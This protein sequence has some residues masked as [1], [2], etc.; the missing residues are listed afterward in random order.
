VIAFLLGRGSPAGQGSQPGTAVVASSPSPGGAREASIPTNTT[1]TAPA[2]GPVAD[3]EPAAAVVRGKVNQRVES[4]GLA[5]TVVGVTNEP[6]FKEVTA[7]PASQKFVGV[8]VLLENTGDSGHQYFSTSFKIK[9]PQDRVYGSGGLGV[10]DPP[11]DWGTI[12]Q[13]EKVRGHIAFVVP[14][15]ATGLTVA[16]MPPG[17]DPSNY[18]PIHIDLGQ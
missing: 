12:V 1:R 5:I 7:P 4:A 9:D 17:G 6:R 13:G 8:E 14:K 11:L 15:D 18:R 3:S 10:G 16:Y 2:D